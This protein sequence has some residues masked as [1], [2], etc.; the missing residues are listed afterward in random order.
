MANGNRFRKLAALLAVFVVAA[1]ANAAAG[2]QRIA[3][4]TPEAGGI[5]SVIASS[6]SE[7][8]EAD[9]KLIDPSLAESA[10]AASSI[11][12]PY[13]MTAEDSRNLASAI[14]CD[15]LLIV[16]SET[17]RRYSSEKKEHFESFAAVFVVSG[18]MG[19]LA[20]FR[21]TS[22]SGFKSAD[23]ERL[24]AESV[25][26]IAAS[27]ASTIAKPAA[28]AN[29]EDRFVEVPA[30]GSQEARGFRPP[31]PYRRISP[32]YTQTAW[33]YSIAATV[34]IEIDLDETGTIRRAE[35]VRWAGFGLDAAV[36]DAVRNMNW[37]AAERS[38]TKVP[39]RFVLRYNFKRIE[40]ED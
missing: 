11:E 33:L 25:P 29:K 16:R 26:G 19:L 10:F 15:F 7:Q 8:L 24:L 32:K 28:F 9:H 2:K 35:V 27:V 6:L 30:E 14:G 13:N 5:V 36:E 34:D 20:D 21:L 4:L 18:R 38:G 40:K 17:I 22:F 3:I 12:S 31:R 1:F 23:S 37:W 39:T